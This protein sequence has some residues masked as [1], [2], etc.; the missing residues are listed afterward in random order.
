MRPTAEAGFA[1]VGS[2]VQPLGVAIAAHGS[3]F[4]RLEKHRMHGAEVPLRRLHAR[5]ER[6][7]RRGDEARDGGRRDEVH[8]DDC[9]PLPASDQPRLSRVPDDIEQRCGDR[10]HEPREAEAPQLQFSGDAL[11]WVI[12]RW[13]QKRQMVVGP[14]VNVPLMNNSCELASPQQRCARLRDADKRLACGHCA[15]VTYSL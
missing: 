11:V 9:W 8:V 3:R 5:G 15:N 7:D 6:G 10:H 1:R 13:A 12:D 4:A 2:R 14:T